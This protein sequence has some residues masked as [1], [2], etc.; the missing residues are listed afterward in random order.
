M[1]AVVGTAIS[2][3]L[4]LRNRAARTARMEQIDREYAMGDLRATYRGRQTSS[5]RGATR[6]ALRDPATPHALPP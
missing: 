5:L 1:A 6:P 3:A 4:F 2:G